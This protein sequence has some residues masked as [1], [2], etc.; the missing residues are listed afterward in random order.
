MMKFLHALLLPAVLLGAWQAL[1][2]GLGKP[3]VLPRLE[4]IGLVLAHPTQ[5][6][7][8]SGSLL[9]GTLVSLLRVSLGFVL[10]AGHAH[11]P[12]PHRGQVS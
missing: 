3:A 11:G 6:V 5:R 12:Q 7:L 10:A 4:D 2:V 8:I 9:E 1:A